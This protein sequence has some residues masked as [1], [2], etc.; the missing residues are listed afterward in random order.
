MTYSPFA[1]TN[2]QQRLREAGV[3]TLI[4]AGMLAN[5]TVWMT[6]REAADRDVGVVVAIDAS[7]SETPS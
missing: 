1:G 5:Y 3:D 2:L 6:A 4:V 7:A